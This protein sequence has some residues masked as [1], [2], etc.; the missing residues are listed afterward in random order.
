MHWKHSTYTYVKR[1]GGGST[2]LI[3]TGL[4]FRIEGR[5]N[6]SAGDQSMDL[7]V[8]NTPAI[9]GYLPTSK[10]SLGRTNPPG[11]VWFHHT[12]YHIRVNL[13]SLYTISGM[14]GNM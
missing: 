11:A 4:R 9:S 6:I 2:F 12:Q 3:G 10:S 1:G 7:I 14:S 13:A 8:G 5:W